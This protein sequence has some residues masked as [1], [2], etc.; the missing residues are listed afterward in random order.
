MDDMTSNALSGCD[1]TVYKFFFDR[2]DLTSLGIQCLGCGRAGRAF[3]IRQLIEKQRLLHYGCVFVVRGKVFLRARISLALQLAQI[4]PCF[5]FRETAIVTAVIQAV[6]CWSIGSS[7]MVSAAQ[8]EHV[9]TYY[10][11]GKS[12]GAQVVLEPSKRSEGGFFV[13]PYLGLVPNRAFFFCSFTVG[14]L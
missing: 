6:I 10:E 5:F 14:H 12:E 3:R 4:R 2:T 13:E 8:N 7:S 9:E 11:K 1:D